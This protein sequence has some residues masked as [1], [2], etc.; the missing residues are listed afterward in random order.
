MGDVTALLPEDW[1]AVDPMQIM[2]Y[3]LK[4]E[5]AGVDA[6]RGGGVGLAAIR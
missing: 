4:D 6:H 2:N 5:D 1:E 3:L